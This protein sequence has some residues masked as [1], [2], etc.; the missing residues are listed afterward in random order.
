MKFY[1][2]VDFE[3]GACIVGQAGMTLTASKQYQLAQKVMTGETNAAVAACFESGATEVIVDD[4]HGG[5]LNLLYDEIDPRARIL[6]GNPRPRRFPV[7]DSSFMGMMLIGYHPMAGT[8][9]GVLS[10]SYSSGAIQ[11]AWLNGKPI[12]EIGLD[13]AQAGSLGVPVI[14]VSSCAAGVKEAKETLGDV[15]TVA[16][17][18][19]LS[20]N[21]AVSFSPETARDLITN[22]VRRAIGRIKDFKPYVVELPCELKREFKLETQ[23]DGAARH[24]GAERVDPLTVITRSDSLFDIW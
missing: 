14:F 8:D 9:R 22:A 2:S 12:G 11:H 17:K 21:A 4:C 16:T 7:L 19:G 15:E 13:S 3:G 20:R 1:I 23:A 6:L 18:E 10:H 24:P 5:G